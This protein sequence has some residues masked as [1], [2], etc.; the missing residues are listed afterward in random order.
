MGNSA[1]TPQMTKAKTIVA[2]DQNTF[3]VAPSGHAAPPF[4]SSARTIARAHWTY[5]M[6]FFGETR[7]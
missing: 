6:L 3:M 5:E 2:V 4:L 7:R 1:T